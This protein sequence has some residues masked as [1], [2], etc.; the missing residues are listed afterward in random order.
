[1]NKSLL[2]LS[3]LAV[4]LTAGC[5]PKETVNIETPDGSAKVTTDPNTGEIKMDVKDASGK[6]GTIETSSDGNSVSYKSD[7]GKQ[8]FE[9]S[10]DNKSAT[11]KATDES[12]KTTSATTNV[13]VNLDELGVPAYP[14]AAQ[15]PDGSAKV[16]GPQGTQWSVQYETSDDP[17]K[18][19]TFYEGKLKKT[20]STTS[21]TQG[22]F[23]GNTSDG[24]TVVITASSETENKKTLI[25]VLV[26]VPKK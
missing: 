1:M 15:K 17:T 22:M 20:T 5:Q 21:G 2:V 24:K 6:S 25:S 11:W 3:A 19:V 16:D 8:S 9:M 7:D 13:S 23:M 18:V 4:L 14:G 26:T 10:G 12:G